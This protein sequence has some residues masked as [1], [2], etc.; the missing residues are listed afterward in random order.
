MNV[1]LD[2]R[3]QQDRVGVQECI[4]SRGKGKK[5]SSKGGELAKTGKEEKEERI[6]TYERVFVERSR[7]SRSTRER[8]FLER[9]ESWEYYERMVIIMNWIVPRRRRRRGRGGTRAK[10]AGGGA[11]GAGGYRS[12][13]GCGRRSCGQ[14]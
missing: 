13:I 1:S 9:R 11:G 3:D 2:R 14:A 8:D 7:F 12:P 6:V 10:E 5:D 4:K